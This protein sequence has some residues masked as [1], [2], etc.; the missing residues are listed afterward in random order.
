MAY[1]ERYPHRARPI[2]KRRNATP[3]FGLWLFLLFC[4]ILAAY[5]FINS[6]FFS[7][8]YI[9][10]NNENT[11]LADEIIEVSGLT[12]GQ[13]LFK[14]NTK[15]AVLKIEAFPIIKNVKIQRKIPD[16]L[17]ITVLEREPLA[18]V[19][20]TDGFIVVDQE[21]ILLK[22]IKDLKEVEHLPVVSGVS[23]MENAQP[24]ADCLS[25]G[26]NTALRLINYIDKDFLV[27][28]VEIVARSAHSLTLKTK[29]GIEVR[30]GEPVDL[31]RKIK[32]M[33]E[34]LTINGQILN[35]ETVEYI[36]LRYN[37][38]PVIKRKS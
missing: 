23:V 1:E 6:A 12:I 4:C 34:L 22:R 21:G 28:V 31:E 25:E 2:R 26:L 33:E 10:V 30:F 15:E 20:I 32:V 35:S 7:V 13:N 36:D 29:Q 37:T 38:A 27:N 3:G 18:L 5:F 11:L 8:K 16:T 24:G 19:V 17:V 9:E 14:V